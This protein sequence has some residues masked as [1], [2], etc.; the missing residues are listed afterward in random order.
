MVMALA[1]GGVVT[2]SV[3]EAKPSSTKVGSKKAK[4]KVAKRQARQTRKKR[5]K[6]KRCRR[7]RFSGHGVSTS[8]LRKAPLPR[9][10]GHVVVSSPALKESVDVWIY[11]EDGSYNQKALAALDRLFRCR[12]THEERAADPRLYEILSIL[13]DHFGKPIELNSGFRFQRNEGSRHFHASAM[14]VHIE[15]VSYRTLYEFAQTLDRGGMG[16]GQYPRSDFVHI[17]FR[18]PGEPSYRWTDTSGG[19]GRD[20]GKLPSRMWKG[21]KP[22]S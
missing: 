8:Q 9:P 18:A 3:A 12:K 22:S 14:D 11:N 10:S 15:G 1:L 17:D 7:G 21:N 4:K 19:G 13:Y 2:G 20:P 6:G 16:I 5:C